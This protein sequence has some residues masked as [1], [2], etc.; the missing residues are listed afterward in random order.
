[1]AQNNV[2]VGRRSAQKDAEA[3]TALKDASAAQGADIVEE[4]GGVYAVFSAFGLTI[5]TRIG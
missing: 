4:D 2:N 5:K 3:A 1:M